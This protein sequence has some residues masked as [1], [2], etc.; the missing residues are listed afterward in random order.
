MSD[1]MGFIN[2]LVLDGYTDMFPKVC[3]VQILSDIAIIKSSV[4]IKGIYKNMYKY[5]ESKLNL[6]ESQDIS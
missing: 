6:R 2:S 1:P 3:H 4:L 5:I